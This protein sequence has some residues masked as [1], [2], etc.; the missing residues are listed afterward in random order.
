MDENV[1]LEKREKR[2]L[3]SDEK[4]LAYAVFNLTR[5]LKMDYRNAQGVKQKANIISYGRCWQLVTKNIE[6]DEQKAQFLKLHSRDF[7]LNE[8][9][10]GNLGFSIDYRRKIDSGKIIWVRNILYLKR[11]RG[12]DTLLYEYCYDIL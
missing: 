6:N 5:N 1:Y 7:L 9:E 11:K 8:Y 2:S 12:M 4:L 10:A 3:L